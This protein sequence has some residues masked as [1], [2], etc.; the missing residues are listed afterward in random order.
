LNKIIEKEASL[1]LTGAEYVREKLIALAGLGPNSLYDQTYAIKVRVKSL[2]S[3]KKKVI[4]KKKEPQK[5]GYKAGDATDLVGMRLLC[6]YGEDLPRVTKSLIAFVRFCQ[7]PEIRLIE[8][9]TLDDAF[10]EVIVYKSNRNARVY[11]TVHRSCAQLGLSERNSKGEEKL[12]LVAHEGDEKSY[13]SIHFVCNGTSYAS[14]QPKR[15]PIEFQ[16]RT[17]FED[18]W[19]EIDHGLE[20]KLKERI[21]RKLPAKL[22]PT[23][24]NYRGFLN[25]LKGHLEDAGQL[26][27]RIKSGYD[28]IYLALNTQKKRQKKFQMR[29]VFWGYPF[30]KTISPSDK[31]RFSELV[32]LETLIDSLNIVRVKVSEPIGSEIEATALL[33]LIDANIQLLNKCLDNIP[34]QDSETLDL[35]SEP[36]LYYFLSMEKALHFQWK[37][38]LSK[39][40]FPLSV[41]ENIHFLEQARDIYFRLEKAAR[42]SLDAMLNFRLGCTMQELG[43]A[44]LASFFMDNAI[45][46][47]VADKSIVKSVFAFIIPH[48]YAFSIWRKRAA[49]LEHG[50]MSQN[51]RISRDEQREIVLEALYYSLIARFFL[52]KMD[53]GDVPNIQAM[54]N[55]VSNN[56][57]SFLWEVRDLSYSTANFENEINMLQVELVD[58][59]PNYVGV[60]L[61]KHKRWLDTKEVDSTAAHSFDTQMK[62]YHLLGDVEKLT[63]FRDLARGMIEERES[64]QK[65]KLDDL[66]KYA[67]ERTVGREEKYVLANRNIKI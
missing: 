63:T 30:E 29:T 17:I 19:G 13:S 42:F 57:I 40:Y 59:F 33:K 15:V 8:G 18:T 14:G 16:V 60:T 46:Y 38:Q 62:Y 9:E 1:A 61:A 5:K 36:L 31:V 6:L 27:E 23:H 45:G 10:H 11:D 43:Q 12:R 24:E 54:R 34:H 55:A 56:V 32:D 66:Y 7:S 65:E 37:A 26:A 41:E 52:S 21:G 58:N 39:F 4:Q 25:D 3:L 49:L 50:I 47:L 28:S 20:Y 64:F 35:F 44:E 2:D 51:P 48:H 53:K 67:Q 22:V